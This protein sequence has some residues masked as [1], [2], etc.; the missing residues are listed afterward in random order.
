MRAPVVRGIATI[1]SVKEIVKLDLERTVYKITKNNDDVI[2]VKGDQISGD[3][4]GKH[5]SILW[6]A[7]L[8]SVAQGTK[9]VKMWALSDTEFGR[10]GA[11]ITGGGK[12]IDIHGQPVGK[13]HTRFDDLLQLIFIQH[14]VQANEFKW[15]KM[16]FIDGLKDLEGI[17]KKDILLHNFVQQAEN[18][19]FWVSLGEI[20]AV[21]IFIGNNDRFD[22]ESGKLRNPGNLMFN[23]AHPVSILLGLD[24]FD[25][26]IAKWDSARQN[27]IVVE[28]YKSLE[29]LRSR[30]N[31]QEFATMILVNLQDMILEEISGP[32]AKYSAVKGKSKIN[33][34][35]FLLDYSAKIV[36]GMEI[37]VNS[38]RRFIGEKK[39]KYAYNN[40]PAKVIPEGIE[41]RA[42]ILFDVNQFKKIGRKKK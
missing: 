7:R 5:M 19:T 30:H 23:L 26:T 37:A 8:M 11:F 3:V 40:D 41:K 32:G 21:D 28:D 24:A 18:D 22:L 16:R 34:D 1:D 39:L 42:A 31:M 36:E 14:V 38:I 2:V 33:V 20:V 10:I 25:R 6:G 17:G 27:L 29:I 4:N 9:D 15:Y 13:P 35:K 12:I